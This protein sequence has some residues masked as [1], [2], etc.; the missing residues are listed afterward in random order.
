[1]GR[2]LVGLGGMGVRSGGGGG[3]LAKGC[4]T[5]PGQ[6]SELFWVSLPLWG[7]HGWSIHCGPKPTS[8]VCRHTL[9]CTYFI[10][11]HTALSCLYE[12]SEDLHLLGSQH[13]SYPTLPELHYVPSLCS[14]CYTQTSSLF[15]PLNNPIVTA[16][17][18]RV[19]DTVINNLLKRLSSGL[20]GV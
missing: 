5:L 10:C 14:M 11:A 7:L 8:L 13:W 12:G 17:E 3:V 19:P 18:T 4:Q 6:R 1:M 2:Q 9:T 20:A 15:F 16:G